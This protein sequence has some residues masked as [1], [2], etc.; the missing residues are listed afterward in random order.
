VSRPIQAGQLQTVERALR[1]L[2]FVAS[3]PDPPPTL[4]DIARAIDCHVST[5]YHVVVTLLANDYLLRSSERTFR[6]G[7]KV[8]FLYAQLRRDIEVPV[9]LQALVA[10][11]G[12]AAQ[13][14]AYL[15]G[16]LNG[17]VVLQVVQEGTHTLRVA[18]LYPG[19]RGLAHC[20]AS[21]KAILAHLRPA[22]REAVLHSY[23]LAA[24]TPNTITEIGRLKE[25][26]DVVARQ[27]FA[28]DLEEF[29]LGVCCVAVP[30]FDSHQVVQGAFAVAAPR[31]R[32]DEERIDLLRGLL[33]QAANRAQALLGQ[34]LPEGAV[35][36]RAVGR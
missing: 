3:G 15:A 35:M 12:Q 19:F 36:G 17:D 13:E 27:G 14:T 30:Y 24:R 8:A 18:G 16:W 31:S 9:E 6:L 34:A 22:L 11:L 29:D 2:E 23:P 26:L 32:F 21:G 1:V 4:Q 10:T 20:R 5:A 33:Q 7:P 28:L 25:E